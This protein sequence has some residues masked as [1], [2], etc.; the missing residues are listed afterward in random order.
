MMAAQVKSFIFLMA[1]LLLLCTCFCSE[2]S[3]SKRQKR[4]IMKMMMHIMWDPVRLIRYWYAYDVT[5][6]IA[7]S[8]RKIIPTI[9]LLP[10]SSHLPASSGIAKYVHPT[11]GV[12][13]TDYHKGIKTFQYPNVPLGGES[14]LGHSF[15]DHYF[16]RMVQQSEQDSKHLA[17]PPKNVHGFHQKQM[18]LYGP[19]TVYRKHVNGG[20]DDD[21]KKFMYLS[22]GGYEENKS[23][24][25]TIIQHV[26]HSIQDDSSNKLHFPKPT[27]KKSPMRD[28]IIKPVPIPYEV[29]ERLFVN[30]MSSSEIKDHNVGFQS[31]VDHKDT[32]SNRFN[33]VRKGSNARDQNVHFVGHQEFSVSNSAKQN[34]LQLS[35]DSL[36]YVIDDQHQ[37]HDSNAE[38]EPQEVHIILHPIP[39]S[40]FNPI[41]A[42][43]GSHIPFNMHSN[44]SV[45]ENIHHI[46]ILIKAADVHLNPL[47][48]H[49]ESSISIENRKELDTANKADTVNSI[50]LLNKNGSNANTENSNTSSE[51]D[52][53]HSPQVTWISMQNAKPTKYKD[54]NF[55]LNSDGTSIRISSLQKN[56]YSNNYDLHNQNLKLENP[57]S[58]HR[59]PYPLQ[60][61]GHNIDLEQLR[62]DLKHGTP[63]LIPFNRNGF[64]S[65]TQKKIISDENQTEKSQESHFSVD[66][67]KSSEGI[68]PNGQKPRQEEKIL[69]KLPSSTEQF[70]GSTSSQKLMLFLTKKKID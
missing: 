38:Q 9:M 45:D 37:Q 49:E 60:I 19:P 53:K 50:I 18:I 3:R 16:H 35:S 66:A 48:S 27:S 42:T 44:Q 40:N 63:V 62:E 33:H 41:H 8:W 70:N 7:K 13:N 59:V 61:N 47:T 52:S 12:K 58:L 56:D 25:Q 4:G 17:A 29:A 39:V 69:H 24:E 30:P 1:L 57:K 28:V 26:P 11:T 15:S 54:K 14:Y 36:S 6:E 10:I 51:T 21:A 34:H 46:P 2:S 64:T 67:I 23:A 32:T 31:S 22:S 68:L 55:D 20:T 43:Y 65:D 5:K